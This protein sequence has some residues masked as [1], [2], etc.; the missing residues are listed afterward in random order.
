[1][2]AKYI[3]T[4]I[5]IIIFFNIDSHSYYLNNAGSLEIFEKKVLII[6]SYNRDY[7]HTRELE[8]G[9][10]SVFKES[11]FLTS[12]RYEFLDTKNYFSTQHME[13]L[14]DSLVEKYNKVNIDGIIL[15]DDDALNFYIAYGHEIFGES[16][17]VV[18]TGIN[19]IR[20]FADGVS[21]VVIMEERPNYEKNIDLAIKQNKEI[22]TLSFI[23]DITTTSYEILGDLKILLNAKYSGFKHNHYFEKTPEEIKELVENAPK[24]EVFFLTIYSRSIDGR[25]YIY[26]EFSKYI[27]QNSTNP[28]Y[29]FWEFYMDSGVLGGYVAS[30][31]KYGESAAATLINIWDEKIVPPIIY[32]AGLNHRYI[33]DYNII[34]KYKINNFPAS[35]IFINRPPTIWE[36]HKNVIIIS[37]IIVSLLT[38]IIILQYHNTKSH[39]RENLLLKKNE[40]IQRDINSK[41]EIEVNNRTREYQLLNTKL[42]LSLMTTEDKNREITDVNQRLT[43]SL[44]TLRATQKKLIETEK[45]ASLGNLVAGISHEINTPLGISL[46]GVSFIEDRLNDLKQKYDTQSLKKSE[47]EDFFAQAAEMNNSILSS[48]RHSISLIGSFKKMAIDHSTHSKR[49]FNLCEYTSEII[50]SLTPKLKGNHINLSFECDE[51]IEYYGDPSWMFQIITNFIDNSI[52]H[53]F[54]KNMENKQIFLEIEKISDEIILRYIDNGKG[55]DE[56]GKNK[57]FDPFFTTNRIEGGSGIGL[58]IVYNIATSALDGSIVCDSEPNKGMAFTIRFPIKAN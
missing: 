32:E 58:N 16:I 25:T 3:C 52:K 14:R 7:M 47:L 29:C 13:A 36:K 35:S 33:F 43:E 45:M 56:V 28:I 40:E 1:M 54:E 5:L 10:E 8:A 26:D 30:S 48:L 39:Q 44:E 21:G 34:Q 23:Y 46:T 51:T 24:N 15:C 49:V 41:L 18:A 17:P 20:K 9:I 11:P 50:T 6:Q 31:I 22:D 4:L 27:S 2:K 19:S 55:I 53:G 57:I 38:I 42:E 37:S 12:F